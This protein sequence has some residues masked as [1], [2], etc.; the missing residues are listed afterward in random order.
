[1]RTWIF[2]LISLFGVFALAP[3][4]AAPT[5]AS[6]GGGIVIN[7]VMP[8]PRID[9]SNGFDTDGN[10]VF[11]N[12][13][14]YIELY[15]L[16]G[17][18]IDIGGWQLWDSSAGLWFTF[19][20][21]STVGP[22]GYALVIIGVQD[23]GTLPNLPPG[24]LT[25]DAAQEGQ[26]LT[27]SGDN[28]TLLDP[29]NTGAEQYIQATYDDPT[30][31]PTAYA[32]FPATATRVGDVE[33]FIA[34][35][36]PQAVSLTRSPAGDTNIVR[37]DTLFT[38]GSPGTAPDTVNTPPTVVA[39]TPADNAVDV[40]TG[41]AI[42]IQF[43]QLVTVSAGWYALTCDSLPR[44][45][46]HS[47]NSTTYT[48]TPDNPLPEGAVCTVTIDADKVT[49]ANAPLVVM[50]NDYTLTFSTLQTVD[51][52]AGFTFI[53][54]IRG[55]NP[56]PALLGPVSTVGI[57]V[58]DFQDGDSQPGELGGFFIQTEPDF[59]DTNVNTS[60]GI[61]VY[62]PVT[63]V[64]VNVG[65]R[66][67]VEG[68]SELIGSRHQINVGEG[69]NGASVQRCDETTT[70]IEET[71]VSVRLADN[72]F[73]HWRAVDGML[74]RLTNADQPLIVSDHDGLQRYG[75][76][77]V[78]S[79]RHRYHTAVNTP[80]TSNAFDAY[81]NTI[82]QSSM[83]VD[84]GSLVE[85]P[86]PILYPAGGLTAANTL[87]TGY[88]TNGI[89]GILLGTTDE[90][91]LEYVL[92]PTE[93][94]QFNG[95]TNPRPA[96]PPPLTGTLSIAT[97]HADGPCCDSSTAAIR[98]RDKLI[99]TIAAL[100]ADI[101]GV[102]GMTN[103]AN[104][105]LQ[106]LVDGVN[107]AVGAG[108]YTYINTGAIG[109]H[110]TRTAIIYKPAIVTPTG[111]VAVLIGSVNSDYNDF[112]HKP[113]VAQTF[114]DTN[115]EQITVAVTQLASRT[116]ANC[117]MISNVFDPNPGFGSGECNLNRTL[118][119]QAITNWL[120]TDP[121]NSGDAD[122]LILGD[123]QAYAREDPLVA[124]ADGGY[125]DL[126]TT[127]GNGT[128]YTQAL[129]HIDNTPTV[130]LGHLDYAL[131]SPSLFAQVR[132]VG[133][134][135]INTDEPAALDYTLANKSATQ[136][137]TLYNTSAFRSAQ[138]DPI[139]IGVTLSSTAAFTL[140]TPTGTITT[141]YGN[142]TYSWPEVAGMVNYRLAVVRSSD[143]KTIILL[144]D[145]DPATVC[146]SGLCTIEPTQISED[147]RLYNGQ[148]RVWVGTQATSTRWYGP[149]PFS[150]DAPPPTIPTLET[151][152]G[153]DSGIST[154]NWTLNDAA[155]NASWFRL[156]VTP[157]DPAGNK[158]VDQWV[159]RADLCEVN[160]TTCRYPLSTLRNG[161]TYQ[162]W[163][164]TYGPGGFA[165]GG[166]DGA[167]SWAGPSVFQVTTRIAQTPSQIAVDPRQGRP[168]VTWL[169]D[170][171]ASWYRVYLGPNPN[172]DNYRQWHRADTICDLMTRVCTVEP[173]IDWNISGNP[174]QVWV[175]GW[176]PQGYSTPGG[177][178]TIESWGRGPD[179]SF[180]EQPAG[181]PTQITVDDPAAPAPTITWRSDLY[182]TWYQ[183]Y[184]T[185]PGN[186]Y[187]LRWH[188]ATDLGCA[189]P[190]TTC[191]LSTANTGVQWQTGVTY[192][193]Y[194]RAWGPG[195]FSTGGVD[196][197]PQFGAGS[198]VYG[199]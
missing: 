13:D 71:G 102:I 145:L 121:T 34:G 107:G 46:T 74:I 10:G 100:D 36:I 154:L 173:A 144:N 152:T 174:Y 68:N 131:A 83:R 80:T 170:P 75:Q 7:E 169:Y 1:M 37:H 32:G 181:L 157:T 120:A 199:P 38:A 21:N 172:G 111:N 99:S 60:E 62:D 20:L 43:S 115:G 155:V 96:V 133:I 118:A 194:I 44:T 27:V 66:V 125:S 51:C 176:G 85:Y 105:A 142:P 53:H 70:T 55:P 108:T 45:A 5:T 143:N 61:F 86:D 92:Q 69:I 82:A 64:D 112:L 14:E 123:L 126:L 11:D 87:R 153:T 188:Q 128:P 94:P 110:D 4:N 158:I 195:G 129:T 187:N 57:V 137:N 156:I 28:I 33:S 130:G 124:F 78:S 59:E 161:T 136:V 89:I 193:I 63:R 190:F 141:A 54:S 101:I 151:T 16:S 103:D 177:Q 184:V 42:T 6:L 138:R 65:D 12:R 93:P 114:T 113:T 180:V 18:S 165:I 192:T 73:S 182:A 179:W 22:G 119:A 146:S 149:F 159:R 67:R 49:D 47:V 160:G 166:P 41:S 90:T 50:Q 175:Q 135:H 84:D 3:V 134:W 79:S 167:A 127:R 178:N 97:M 197:A 52:E 198:F 40:D 91:L 117:S 88:T 164:Q 23:G 29:G 98:Q 122:V 25:F 163:L 147:Y 185:A 72:P 48:I 95:N 31:D 104:I 15:N 132:D 9:E 17:T 30:D 140:I 2:M 150:L 109:T 26:I 8:S 148:Y 168:A 76:F 162:Y 196:D 24:S 19:P 191:T 183:V 116:L 39:T 189:D 186:N 58:G 106:A 81:L 56:Q 77:T 139:M 35:T 171:N